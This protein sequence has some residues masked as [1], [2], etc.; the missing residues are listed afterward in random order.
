MTDLSSDLSDSLS[1]K[2]KRRLRQQRRRERRERQSEMEVEILE[3]ATDVIKL[4]LDQQLQ[5]TAQVPVRTMPRV[6]YVSQERPLDNA[7][8]KGRYQGVGSQSGCT[9]CRRRLFDPV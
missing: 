6:T 4:A 7:K 2:E 9:A 3:R 1:K 8:S 5:E